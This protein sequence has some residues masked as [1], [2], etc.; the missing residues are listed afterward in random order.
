MK[1]I[2]APWRIEYIKGPKEEGCFFCKYSQ[3]NN[4]RKRLIVHRG[5]KS[6]IIMNY[7]PYN[8]GHLMIT[9]Y[10]HISDFDDLD[11]QTKLEMMNYINVCTKALKEKLRAEGFNIGI[12]IGQVAGAGVKDHLHI[13]VVPRWNG[14]TN[15]MPT[16]GSIKVISQ[17]LEDTWKS[18]KQYFDNFNDY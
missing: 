5:K 18:L 2:W 16:I 17:G 13:H 10:E 8:N 9:P 15:F 1:R 11:D 6:F 14:D 7:Y 4:D 3:E 12:N